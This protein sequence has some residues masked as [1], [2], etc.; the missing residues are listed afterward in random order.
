MIHH[1][2]D[3]NTRYES[4]RE[5]GLVLSLLMIISNTYHLVLHYQLPLTVELRSLVAVHNWQDIVIST[6]ILSMLE[7]NFF[8][9][10]TSPMLMYFNSTMVMKKQ[11]TLGLNKAEE[12]IGEH[13]SKRTNIA[14]TFSLAFENIYICHNVKHYRVL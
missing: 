1:V 2:Y 6:E 5:V 11:E 14:T 7:M 13:V 8:N 12:V 10:V 3:L 9:E 4:S